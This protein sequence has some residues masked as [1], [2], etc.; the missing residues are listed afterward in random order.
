[1][2]LVAVAAQD[3]YTT[4]DPL[5]RATGDCGVIGLFFLL[6]PGGPF[7]AASDNDT[8]PF[9][10]QDVEFLLGHS[11]HNAATCD[12]ALIPSPDLVHLT[13]TKQKNG[14]C[15]KKLAHGLTDQVLMLPIHAVLCC[16]RHL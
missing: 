1:M 2:P 12:L 9:R 3:A 13:F 15:S 11:C 7:K 16:I 10:L 5:L 4:L 8:L 14:E 6:V